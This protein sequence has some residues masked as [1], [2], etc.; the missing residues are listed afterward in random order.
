[1]YIYAMCCTLLVAL[2]LFSFFCYVKSVVNKSIIDDEYMFVLVWC[3]Q[4][5]DQV[6]SG[7]ELCGLFS[8]VK[9]CVHE[10]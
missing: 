5:F 7:P 9:T 4:L 6:S 2:L 8:D 3:R 10:S 1:M